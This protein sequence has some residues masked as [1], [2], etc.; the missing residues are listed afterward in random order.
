MS[1][2]KHH[3]YLFASRSVFLV[4]KI[5]G[6]I[7]VGTI[8]FDEGFVVSSSVS[9]PERVRVEDVQLFGDSVVGVK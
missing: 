3:I 2:Y 1:K 7:G 6:I 5:S 4:T 9:E 8:S